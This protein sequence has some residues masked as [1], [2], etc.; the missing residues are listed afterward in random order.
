[1]TTR[2]MGPL[3]GFGWLKRGINVGHRNPKALFGGAALLLLACMLPMFITMPMQFGTLRA[4]T[5][6]DPTALGGIMALSALLGL[7]VVPLYAG[8]LQVIDA[9]ERGQPARARDIFRPYRQGG[10][11]RLIGY[12][13][14]MVVLNC[15]LLAIVVGAAGAGIT[16]WYMEVLAAQAAHQPPPTALPAGFGTAL[17]LFSVFWLF[18]IGVSSVSLGQIALRGRSIF[19]AIGDGFVGAL[20]NLLPL[21][22]FGVGFVVACVVAGIGLGLLAALVA[23]LGKLVGAWLMILLVAVL[24]IAFLLLLFAVMFGVMYALWRDVCGGD[25]MPTAAPSIAA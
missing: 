2:S 10:A 12:G 7:L 16:H 19:G 13:L 1:M 3:A 25:S 24:Y 5:Q 22:V 14:A 4:E 9:G 8:Y 23:L 6:P 15:A 11:L 18:L 17:A 21:L 20:K